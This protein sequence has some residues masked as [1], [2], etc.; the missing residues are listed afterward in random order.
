MRLS[1]VATLYRSAP[2]IDEFCRRA[3]A[4]ARHIAPDY[5]IILFND[6]SPDASLDVA[7]A[8]LEQEPRLRIVDLARNFGHHKAMMTGLEH[9]NG[10][11]VF[12]IDSDL[13]E[14]PEALVAFA[15]E[16]ERTQADV[17]Y[18]VQP[19][20]RGNVF[21]RASGA[22]YYA[23]FNAVTSQRIP[24]NVITARLMTRRYVRALLSYRER[25]LNIGA[26]WAHAG[27]QQVPVVVEK[28][29]KGSTTY[30]LRRKI[31]HFVNSVTSFSATP[32]VFIFYLGVSI[33]L[34]SGVFGTYLVIRRLFFGVLLQGWPSLIVSV[35]FLGGLTLLSVGVIGVYLAKVFSEVKQRPYTIVRAVYAAN[36]PRAGRVERTAGVHAT[37][38]AP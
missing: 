21:E 15:A 6:G 25:E 13:E 23:L 17:V 19:R 33:S 2:Y 8:V 22:L 30:D 18:G 27:F 26:L 37:E 31:S 5:E 35:W 7:L 20:R 24:P 29:H 9:A 16:M 38:R 11:L 12:L 3:A 14:P 10:D 1:I 32:L 36:A 4:A 28:S 34:F